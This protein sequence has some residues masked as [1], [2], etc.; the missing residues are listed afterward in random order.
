ML[1]GAI[2]ASGSLSAQVA[3]NAF[4]WSN[5]EKHIALHQDDRII[6]QL[7]VDTSQ[8]KPYFHP[9]RTPSGLDLTLER[10][11]DHPWHRG[12]WFSWKDING[13]NY[14]EEDPSAGVSEG[15]SVIKRVVAK[16]GKKEPNA[17]IRIQ[18]TYSDSARMVM[19]ERRR[20][21]VSPPEQ[22]GYWIDSHHTFTAKADVTL[23]L[24]K[25]AK[26]GGVG[27]GGY[28]GF[29]F[30]GS[31]QLIDVSFMASSG[32]K[33]QDDLTGYGEKEQ[34]MGINAVNQGKDVSLVIFDDPRNPRYPS[35]WYIW[36]A[37]GQ[38]LFFT[39]SLLFDGPLVLKKGQRLELHY[40]VRVADGKIDKDAINNWRP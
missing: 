5:D 38:N 25:P 15:R 17:T 21:T 39:P 26:H 8:D 6:W 23:Y 27:W 32:W 11:A 16:L 31:D 12:L 9:L 4:T 18:L 29:S 10:P 24:E 36:Y 3:R 19:T 37:K 20:I 28:A 14:W 34:W 2:V 1:L 33:N 7:N 35:P 13:V 30:R 22:G 40:K